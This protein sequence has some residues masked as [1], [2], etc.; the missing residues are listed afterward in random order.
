MG[1]SHVLEL[2]RSSF[3]ILLDLDKDLHTLALLIPL[4][5]K[6]KTKAVFVFASNHFWKCFYTCVCVW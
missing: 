1:H 6:M 5:K 2:D 3:K 4:K